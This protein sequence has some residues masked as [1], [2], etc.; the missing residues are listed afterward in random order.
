M[1]DRNR[2][3]IVVQ[4]RVTAEDYT[5]RARGGG[6]EVAPPADRAGHARRLITALER[7]EDDG[8]RRRQA[9][10]A[11]VAG[12]IPGIYVTFESFPGME[13]AL[14]SLD[15]QQGKVHAEL[16]SVQERQ[17]AAGAVQVATVFVPDG[18]L[19][20]FVRKLEKYVS[21]AAEEK[22]S[23]RTLADPVSEIALASIR[24]L[25]TDL[26][27]DFP[28]AGPQAWWEVWMR[29][30]DGNEPARFTQFAESAGCKVGQTRL[31]FK[32]RTV[33]LVQATVEQLAGAVD[34]LD[35]LA[36]LRR[37]HQPEAVLALESAAEQ[38]EWVRELAERLEAVDSDAPAVC[39]L[40][41]G[42]H[43][44][45]PLLSSALD[46]AD[47]HTCDPR[48]GLADRAGHGTEMAGL[49][50]FGDLGQ[51]M[52][53]TGQVRPRHR[54]ESVKLLPATSG[55]PPH[56]WGALT[57]AAASLVEIQAPTRR[58]TFSMAV[59]APNGSRPGEAG[60]HVGRPTS[61]SAAVDALACGRAIDTTDEGLV[62]LDE[63]ADT[64][65][66][67]FVVSAGNVRV[68]DD[69]HLARSDLEPVEDPAQAWNAL[70]VG[71]YT[72]L[73]DLSDQASYAGW[74]PLAPRDELSPLSRTSVAF[75]QP[76]PVKPD[77]V[78]EGGN[79]AR[80]PDGTGYDTP[81]VFQLL[82]TKALRPGESRLLTVTNAT[83]AATSEAA[84]LVG[85]VMAGYPS[86]WPETLR[87]LV[88][89]SARWTPV[90]QTKFGAARGRR[91]K[92]ALRRRY[93]M[94]VPDLTRATRS[95]WSA[96]K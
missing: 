18:K 20:T 83:S 53:S 14:E 79:V 3:H 65:P 17:T 1:A 91:A 24:A 15:P 56:L 63:D 33:M 48:W 37:P 78:L 42:V 96:R 95:A 46:A 82:T 47:Q 67:L 43:Q 69:D 50:L 40:D 39:V 45:H 27:A 75:A 92:D 8:R 44:A 2:S 73:V 30:R 52:L 23:N 77:V 4:G 62:Y 49:A 71:A 5:R 80:S 59:T 86:L 29:R 11:A 55:N 34:V 12:A 6:D 76:W 35:D 93:G 7:A 89:H 54:L 9:T 28:A 10:S 66:R 58:R 60:I 21:T 74:T 81:E 90:M 36:E 41:T 57:A 31:S 51:V 22:P 26:P 87:A 61:W 32:D 19:G 38:A 68:F 70:T 13:L 88:V 84:H 64:D 16:R 25:W 72:Q 85:S 94:G